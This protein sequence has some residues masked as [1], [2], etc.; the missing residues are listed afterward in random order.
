MSNY[1]VHVGSDPTSLTDLGGATYG[2]TVLRHAPVWMAA[3]QG[4]GN[5]LPGLDGGYSDGLTLRAVEMT[6]PCIVRAS[7]AAALRTQLDAV[8]PLISPRSGDQWWKFDWQS[9]RLRYGRVWDVVQGASMPNLA[10]LDLTLR[11]SDACAYS[12]TSTSQTLTVS[13]TPQT[14]TIPAT[15]SVAGSADARPVWVIKNTS[16][17]ESSALTLTSSTTSESISLAALPNGYWYR[18]DLPRQIVERSSNSGSTWS[19]FYSGVGS[20]TQ[21]PRLEAGSSNSLTLSGLSSGSVVVTY[22]ARYL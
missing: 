14:L 1:S 20:A 11:L 2:L 3:P 5:D 8:L 10:R 15:G 7:T 19:T 6:V 13:S 4:H 9:D 17:S 12:T 16:G 18:L 22:R 21:I